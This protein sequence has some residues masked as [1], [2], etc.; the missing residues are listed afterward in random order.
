M[1]STSVLAQ[2][3]IKRENG[4]SYA[5]FEQIGKTKRITIANKRE[6][7]NTY[8][9]ERSH[10]NHLNIFEIPSKLSTIVFFEFI[11][12][13]KTP[14]MI[15][16]LV[17][18][19]RNVLLSHLKCE[20]SCVAVVIDNENSANGV[21]EDYTVRIQYPLC[22]CA[23]NLL[24]VDIY[25][26]VN[27]KLSE[28]I[29]L[30]TVNDGR[31]IALYGSCN[32]DGS[33]SKIDSVYRDNGKKA[34]NW[35]NLLTEIFEISEHKDY[36]GMLLTQEN[37]NGNIECILPILLSLN[38]HK[39]ETKTKERVVTEEGE[40][41]VDT[42]GSLSFTRKIISMIPD[43]IFRRYHIWKDIGRCIH[44][45]MYGES[46]G[47]ELWI[48]L[49]ETIIS[50]SPKI[51]NGDIVDIIGDKDFEQTLSDEYYSFSDRLTVLTLMEYASIYAKDKFESYMSIIIERAF[52]K[53]LSRIA[54]EVANFFYI[55][56]IQ[57]Y[58]STSSTKKKWY[59][60][61]RRSHRWRCTDSAS[62]LINNMNGDFLQFY[63]KALEKMRKSKI[64][65]SDAKEKEEMQISITKVE[66]LIDYLG[67][68]VNKKKILWELESRFKD[69]EFLSILDT[70]PHYM[71]FGNAVLEAV[72]YKHNQERRGKIVI[73]PG[74][75]EDFISRASNFNINKNLGED[76]KAVKDAEIW[77]SQCFL[78]HDLLWYMKKY[79]SSLLMGGNQDKK[80]HVFLGKGD[81]SKTML[82][83]ALEIILGDYYAAL[84][85]YAISKGKRQNMGGA[86]TELNMTVH[87]RLAVISEMSEHDNPDCASIKSL[88]SGGDKQ[89]L[90]RLFEEG[91]KA[92]ILS[93]P[94]AASNVFPMIKGMDIAGM[95][96]IVFIAM[97]GRWSREAPERLA[98]QLRTK[99]FP[100]D[101]YF[102]ERLPLIAQ[103]ILYIMM[104]TY[105]FYV[106]EG[107]VMHSKLGKQATNKYWYE[108][109]FYAQFIS[110][111][112]TKAIDPTGKR[113][114]EKAVSIEHMYDQF[115]KYY[116][117]KNPSWGL[118]TSS[119]VKKELS[120]RIGDPYHEKWWGVKLVKP[121]ELK[122]KYKKMEKL[123]IH[124]R[125]LATVPDYS[126][127]DEDIYGEGRLLYGNN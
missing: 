72:N 23:Y 124:K 5:L 90:R 20:G 26:D 40:A 55:L 17:K 53:S 13:E 46:V 2:Y 71:G 110:D 9:S 126:G 92:E 74:K 122:E 58:K 86:T 16:K 101:P 68:P 11:Y 127:Y 64:K 30:N 32:I 44:H 120:K 49:T 98:D 67:E 51:K 1:D 60:Y 91:Y 105:P 8:L 97:I 66:A 78:D 29:K 65:K 81:N 83:K 108:N 10:E 118:P 12:K 109:D 18:I 28:D 85:A 57:I 100:R 41:P 43:H 31:M 115:C 107:L 54:R 84:P 73:R 62:H 37:M 56:N 99:T 24:M 47:L 123:N 89:Q 114:E 4:G 38:Y 112:I 25:N 48:Q 80:M 79:L 88:S 69:E 27:E 76:S 50:R 106:K 77:L 52:S 82:F 119:Q 15:K 14:D 34:K 94:A 96:R 103:G 95:E 3:G 117:M 75:P 45:K 42:I 21:I 61:D 121:K 22:R 87:A 93:K 33:I 39:V 35:E 113:E 125:P 102:Y 19:T 116:T 59:Y 6:F 63:E 104:A 7:W 70:N 111:N 36:S